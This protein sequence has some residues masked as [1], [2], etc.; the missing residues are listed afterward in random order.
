ML[1]DDED[2]QEARDNMFKLN[3]TTT[4]T[5]THVITTTSRSRNRPPTTTTETSKLEPQLIFNIHS[6]EQEDIDPE[7]EIGHFIE[8]LESLPFLNMFKQ[9]N[10][11]A[12]KTSI[13]ETFHHISHMGRLYYQLKNQQ[14][15]SQSSQYQNILNASQLS[16]D[17]SHLYTSNT[18]N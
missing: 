6:Q 3:T 15:D 5:T 14:V 9:E 11:A 8:S 12:K 1:Q 4:N 13:K 18:L 10:A 2:Q 16:R 17:G 7:V